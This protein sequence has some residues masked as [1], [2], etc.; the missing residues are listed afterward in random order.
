[1]KS[2]RFKYSSTVWVLLFLVLILSVAGVLWNVFNLI[3]YS[4]AGTFKIAVYTLLVIMTGALTILVLSLMVY[5]KYV[6]KNNCLYT[7]FGV[8]KNKTPIK[9]IIQIT[10]FKKSDK[11]VMYFN[12]NK[13][14]VVVIAK[15]NY[16]QFVLAVRE[17]NPSVIYNAKIDGEDTPY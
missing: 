1:M 7:C 15:E 5:G 17:V 6:I 9:E 2:F 8:F 3:E 13:Y 11:L 14:T 16:E 4:W 10:H 12:D